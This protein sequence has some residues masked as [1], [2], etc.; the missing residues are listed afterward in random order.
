M[1]ARI[2]LAL[3]ML[4]HAAG[5]AAAALASGRN[6][7]I[8][9][10]SLEC[11]ATESLIVIGTRIRYLGPKGPVEAPV[12]RLVDGKGRE[13]PPKSLVWKSGSKALAQWLTSGGL[14]NVQSENIAEIQL[15]FELAGATAPLGLEFGD[16]RA[17]SL[18]RKPPGKSV[19]ESLLKPDEIRAP[20]AARR[21][22]VDASK[23]DFP[24]H[25][26]RYPCIP[27]RTVAA[28]YPPYLPKQLLLFGRGYLPG[29]RQIELPMGKAPA[30][31]YSYAGPDDLI[32]VEQA[33]RQ[34]VMADFPAY[35]ER[36]RY[37]AFN[38]GVQKSQSGNDV[39][40]IGIYELRRCPGA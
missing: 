40:S 2:F 15:K 9:L 27:S 23:L 13:Y 16:V 30:Q 4:C 5:S 19:C 31:P 39:Y 3:V 29:A 7:Q 34:A 10:D 17:F 32:A 36:S 24:V 11:R 33:A 20:R 21:A 38:W 35:A 6:W 37:F 28:E 26:A 8:I 25:R 1:P 12:S 18:T 14:A 22:R